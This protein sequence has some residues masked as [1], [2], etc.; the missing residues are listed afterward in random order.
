MAA[1]DADSA[2]AMAASDSDAD[3]GDVD[4]DVDVD[5]DVDSDVDDVDGG[6]DTIE[7]PASMQ[8]LS[9]WDCFKCEA[10][11]CAAVKADIQSS[12]SRVKITL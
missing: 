1:S 7:I 5:S 11:S 10:S 4:V 9:T 12:D 2:N 3:G 6:D 8:G